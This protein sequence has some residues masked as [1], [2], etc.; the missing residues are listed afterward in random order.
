MPLKHPKSGA[1]LGV[2]TFA[3]DISDRKRLEATLVETKKAAEDASQAKTLFL[4]QVSHELRTPLNAIIG[5]TEM[6]TQEIFGPLGAP[7][8]HGYADD[9]LKS[10][11]HLLGIIADMLDLAK[12]DAAAMALD[13]RSVAAS[14]VLTDAGRMVAP[15]AAAKRVALR[16]HFEAGLPPVKADARR[17]RQ[18]LINL[19]TNA[20]KFT[21]EG[22][23]VLFGAVRSDDGGLEIF[24]EDSGVGMSKEDIEVALL[25]FGR[26]QQGYAKSQEGTGIGLPLAKALIE[27]HGGRFS[28][29]ST[30]GSG[31]KIRALFRQ[32]R[33]VIEGESP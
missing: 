1:I 3:L 6:M 9:V 15:L 31:T 7:Q 24:V 10:A 25:V 26:V 27:R 32:D 19:L 33:L 4:A 8:Y 13:L 22:G 2:A 20:I 29:E 23:T 21:P 17:L 28:I 30:P 14:E 16:K 11:R 12:L 18:A 5:F